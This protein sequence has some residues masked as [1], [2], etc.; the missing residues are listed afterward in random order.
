MPPAGGAPARSVDATPA[1]TGRAALA[2]AAVLALALAALA[3][4]LLPGMVNAETMTYFGEGSVRCMH[5][6]GLSAFTSWCHAYGEPGG[7]PLLT[8]GPVVAVGAL[9]MALPGVDSL[10]AYVAAQLVFTAVGL[11]GGYALMRRLGA[12]AWIALAASAVYAISPSVIG[13]EG[14]GGTFSGFALLPAYAFLDLVVMDR[15]A[16]PGGR[17]STLVLLLAAYALVRTGALF[18]DGYSFFA[19]GLVGACLWIAWLLRR[20]LGG[21]VRAGGVAVAVVAN[22]VAIAL[23]ALYVPID[24]V[25][26]PIEV[27]RSMGLDLVTLAEPSQYVWWA[28]KLGVATD[29]SGL[30]GDSS[31]SMYNYVGLGSLALAAWYLVR[32]PR[33]GRAL[34]LAAAGLVALVLS[35]GPALKVD[36]ARVPGAAVYAMPEGQATELPWDHLLVTVPGLKSIRATYRWFSVTRLALVVLA[37]LGVAEL[38][39]SRRR[40]WRIAAVVAGGA[41]AIELLPTI[42]YFVRVYRANYEDRAQAMAQVTPDLRRTLRPGERVF[43]LN[44]DG[45]HNDFLV[46]DLA[47]AAGLRAYNTGG[48]KNLMFAMSRWPAEVKALVPPGV[49]PAAVEQALRSGRVDAVVAPYFHLQADSQTWP[50]APA[51]VAAARGAFAPILTDPRL[52]VTRAHW[53]A[54]LRLRR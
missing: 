12:A 45:A 36:A 26:S 15:L 21:R 20:G 27:F 5:D 25:A 17:R 53:F 49:G 41:A 19:S 10:G 33:H 13:M 52:R 54:T 40:S 9:L 50:P 14:F 35:F 7:F 48:D 29:H 31:N 42:P 24:Y 30:W 6:L 51:T 2:A 44:Y 43:F 4:G 38:A 22:L 16:R 32:R 3:Q 34:A 18:M 39:R 37:G 1:R 23:Y 8:G 11:A 47:P 28:S 46:N